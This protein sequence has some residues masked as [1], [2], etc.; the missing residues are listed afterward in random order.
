LER[1]GTIDIGT[2]VESALAYFETTYN[3]GDEDYD[4]SYSIESPAGE[5]LGEC[6]ISALGGTGVGAPEGAVAFEVWL[7]DKEDVRTEARV[8]MSEQA[9]A[10]DTLRGEMATRGE[11][12]KAEKGRATTLETANLRLDAAIIELA[13]ERG[14]DSRGFAKLTARLDVFLKEEPV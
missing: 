10:D 11:P 4:V 3:L 13:Y 5:F 8:L 2:L 7:F 12:A 6:G 1:G 14:L 9:F